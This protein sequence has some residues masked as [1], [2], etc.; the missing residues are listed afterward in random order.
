II[1]TV[2]GIAVSIGLG[3]LQ[4]NG[5]LAQVV[6][7]PE[8][9]LWQLIIIGVVCGLATISVS[10][11]LDKGIKVLSNLNIVVA[12]LLLFFIVVFGPTLFMAKGVFE[13]LG[14]YIQQ[15]PE[16]ALWN[17]TFANT[18]WQ[19]TWTVFYWAWT[20]T[21]SPLVGIFIARISRGRTIRQ[22]VI[23]VLAVPSAFS[24]LWF[25]IFGYAS[26]DIELNGDG[27]LVDRVVDEGDIPGALFA[28][29]SHYPLA[30][31]IS[32]I[33]ILLVIIFFV[34]SV[35]SAA[36]VVD[37]MNNGHE[38][39][40]PLPQR[41]FWAL[42]VA[43]VTATLLVFS[44]TGGLEALQS[45]IILVGLPFFIIAYFQIYALMRALRED[46][47]VLPR[48]R[49]RRWK[50]V[51]PPEEVE[52]RSADDDD[53]SHEYDE[54]EEVVTRPQAEEPA[55]EFRDPY[56]EAPAQRKQR[57]GTLASRTGSR[58]RSQDDSAG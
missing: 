51:L 20:I 10:L 6:G 53:F 55:P 45:T 21:W 25:G 52:R 47:G 29:L 16:L 15:L 41:I 17:D 34:T 37:T 39:F 43:V 3:T 14:T 13:S 54:D 8:N 44:G 7:V 42:A 22:F 30:G 40:N 1:G 23:G 5:G 57:H 4:I 32:V 46:A 49:M 26:F 31:P 2:F 58:S 38:D 35:D 27:G 9:A 56:I 19:N 12:V 36:L 24:I 48:V 50:K 18:G 33:A 11:G 28:F